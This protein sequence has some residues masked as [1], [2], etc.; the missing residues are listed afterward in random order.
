MKAFVPVFHICLIPAAILATQ[1]LDVDTV[2]EATLTSDA[3]RGAVED[4]VLQT[5]GN[6]VELGGIP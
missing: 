2:N 6:P 1:R 4:Y 3:I 5:G